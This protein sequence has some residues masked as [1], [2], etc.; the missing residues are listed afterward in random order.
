MFEEEESVIQKKKPG[1]ITLYCA[2]SIVFISRETAVLQDNSCKKTIVRY[3]C[4]KCLFS[5]SHSFWKNK[6]IFL[7][8]TK[9]KM[10]EQQLKG[11]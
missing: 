7:M 6:K 11:K 2:V 8:E 4:N 9:V 3:N 10:C 5:C 1:T